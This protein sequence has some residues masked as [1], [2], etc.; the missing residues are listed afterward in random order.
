MAKKNTRIPRDKTPD[1]NVMEPI[2]ITRFGTD[3]DPCFGKE[4][5]LASPECKRCGDSELCAIVMAQ[6]NNIA[7]KLIESENRFKDLEIVPKE[8]NE[9]L[10]KWVSMKIDEGLKRSEII[11]KAKNTYGSTR[12]E[13]KEIYAKLKR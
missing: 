2:D 6:N 4:Y 5:N 7:R 12:E 9:A 8:T 1:I 3:E 13:I 11:K 10:K